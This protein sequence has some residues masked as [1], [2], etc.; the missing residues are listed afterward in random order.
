MTWLLAP[1]MALPG[2]FK[3]QD[4]PAGTDPCGTQRV[5]L[6]LCC[7]W[8]KIFGSARVHVPAKPASHPSRPRPASCKAVAMIL[9]EQGSTRNEPWSGASLKTSSVCLW[10]E[11]KTHFQE[12]HLPPRAATKARPEEK[13]TATLPLSGSPL[14]STINLVLVQTKISQTKFDFIITF[15]L[16]SWHC[17][18]PVRLPDNPFFFSFCRGFFHPLRFTQCPNQS[19]VSSHSSQ[20][21]PLYRDCK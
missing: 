16:F 21:F 6:V 13:E 2:F 9:R 15:H 8:I 11:D 1:V 10:L 7:W 5:T 17:L 3:W 12:I 20:I 4:L 14:P 19:P 18:I